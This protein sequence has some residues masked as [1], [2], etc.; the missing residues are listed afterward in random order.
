VTKPTAAM[1]NTVMRSGNPDESG[2]NAI[3]TVNRHIDDK[4]KLFRRNHN[5]PAA[6]FGCSNCIKKPNERCR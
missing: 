2:G 5:I 4:L 6:T 1:L 3:K